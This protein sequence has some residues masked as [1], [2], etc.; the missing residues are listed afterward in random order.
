MNL[1]AIIALVAALVSGLSVYK[2][3]EWRMDS[4]EKARVEQ[5]LVDQRQSAAT[6]IRRQDNV[7]TAQNQAQARLS[8]LRVDAAGTRNELDGLRAS[9]ANFVRDAATSQT[10]CLERAATLSK[11]FIA[12]TNE[13]S[14]VAERAGRHASDVQTLVDAWPTEPKKE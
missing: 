6:T 14:E 8:A 2:I 4:K 1:T 11:L 7:I 10:A 3:Q 5:I 12:S 9:T 13:Y